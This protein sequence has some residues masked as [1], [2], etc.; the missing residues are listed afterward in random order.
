[1]PRSRLLLPGLIAAALYVVLAVLVREVLRP[2]HAE[3]HGQ[4]ISGFLIGLADLLQTPGRVAVRVLRLRFDPDDQTA[5]WLTLLAF[6]ATAYLLLGT[7]GG[8]LW[9]WLTPPASA[10][11]ARRPSGR[12]RFLATAVKAGAA[13]GA[14]G[15][16]YAL[17][18]EPRWFAVTR[19]TLPV[20]DLPPELDGLRLVQLTDIHHGPWLSQGYVRR[21]VEAANDLRPDLVLL[22]GD[23][24][25]DSPR[26]IGPIV[27][28]LAR[29]RPKVGCV[30]VLGNHDWYVDGPRTREE[31]TRVGVPLL[32][33]GRLVLTPDRRLVADAPAGLALCGVGDLW[34]DTQD[35][36]AALAGL[37]PG[38]PRL[39]LS[40]NPDVAEE[41]EFVAA[42][43]RVDYM[44]SGHTHG[45]QVRVPLLGTPV[46]P[47]RYGQK[48]ASG[49][50]QGP[51]CP[52]FVCRGIGLSVLPVRLGVSPEIAVL[53]LTAKA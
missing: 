5:L 7:L 21:V 44:I 25:S 13:A 41:P 12:R 19:R 28:E 47:S 3:G 45:G 9:S 36:D 27:A 42:G 33:N 2:L 51:A 20:R 53:E 17:V 23:Y 18:A 8:A 35:Y 26:Y 24:V 1:M 11:A 22:T 48:Y 14:A 39:L 38:M 10:G 29:L 4:G 31:L 40:H 30:A 46:V 37:P 32:D 52:V 16:G 34:T 49:L 43:H 6:S 15:F 50:V